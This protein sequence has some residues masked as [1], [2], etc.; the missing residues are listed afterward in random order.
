MLTIICLI[1][2][3]ILGIPYAI[4]IIFYPFYLKWWVGKRLFYNL[5]GWHLPENKKNEL[6]GINGWK[7]IR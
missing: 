7:E 1:L 5:M 4:I 3:V 6:L 2:L